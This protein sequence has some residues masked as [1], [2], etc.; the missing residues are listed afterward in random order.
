M[1]AFPPIYRSWVMACHAL[2]HQLSFQYQV[3]RYAVHAMMDLIYTRQLDL[4]R[5]TYSSKKPGLT[6]LNSAS[7][8][9][10]FLNVWINWSVRWTRAF[11]PSSTG[12]HEMLCWRVQLAVSKIPFSSHFQINGYFSLTWLLKM[13]TSLNTTLIFRQLAIIVSD[14]IHGTSTVSD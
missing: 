11:D 2:R 12:M 5:E 3:T 13:A 14:I 7:N 1:Q 4:T 6:L 9:L 8:F 10:T